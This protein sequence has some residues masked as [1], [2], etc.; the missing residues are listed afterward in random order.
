[1]A[2]QRKTVTFAQILAAPG[3]PA[4][5]PG[6][7]VA[8]TS[9]A[10]VPQGTAG[11]TTCSYKLV[12]VAASGKRSLGT[13]NI[14]TATANATQTS[15]NKNHI[16]WVDDP[17][18]A[19]V[20]VYRTAGGADQ[21]YIGSVAAGVQVFDDTGI[22]KAVSPVLPVATTRK[23][24]FVA[25]G[26]AKL[27]GTARRS[28]ASSEASSAVGP[29]T[30]SA[31][32]PMHCTWATVTGATGYQIWRT[33]I[34]VAKGLI[35]TV[36]AGVTAFNDPGT[37]GDGNDPPTA[38]ETG[39][40]EA[41]D[42][43]ELE[44]KYLQVG[45]TFVGTIQPQGSINGVEWVDEGAAITAPGIQAVAPSYELMRFK[46]TAFTSGAP[47]IDVLGRRLQA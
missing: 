11:V 8:P 3:S 39:I 16:T 7:M 31:D 33:D 28:V 35:G 29:E 38:D 41:I 24:K 30:L 13:A 4:D 32:T 37:V 10:V 17:G 44:A 47:T 43:A 34:L 5:A 23:Y 12:S 22:A 26:V 9:G 15:V 25:L 1:M 21:G 19:T 14:T 6:G 27:N 18:A 2:S 40:S 20:E 45:G 42:V 36:A 46:N